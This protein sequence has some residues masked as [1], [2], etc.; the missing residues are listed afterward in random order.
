MP[1]ASRDSIAALI[2]EVANQDRVA[3]CQL[4]ND[5]SAKL[6]GVLIRILDNRAEAEDALQD[7]FVKV[8]L[9]AQQFDAG[10]GRGMTWLIAVTRNQAI[11]RLRAN[12]RKL[13]VHHDFDGLADDKPSVESRMIASG[14]AQ[15]LYECIGMLEPNRAAALRGAYIEGKSYVDL[16]TQFDMPLNSMRTHLR[17][18]LIKLKVAMTT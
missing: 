15:Y 14:E 3:F 17:R 10:K 4:Y 5:T 11:N 8:W 9:Q 6:M 13:T 18:S 16:A 2:S 1:V 7:V 12:S